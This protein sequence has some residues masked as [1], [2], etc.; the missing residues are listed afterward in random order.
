MSFKQPSEFSSFWARTKYGVWS[1]IALSWLFEVVAESVA[2]LADRYLSTTEL[3]H[4]SI[5][6]F[7]FVIWLFWGPK[8]G[9]SRSNVSVLQ[10]YQFNSNSH[11]DEGHLRT[12]QV[13]MIELQEQH[14]ISQEYTLPF[15]Y[16]CQIYHLLNL[17]HLERIHDFSLNNLKVVE[18]S[19]FQFTT[20][21]GKLRFKTILDS[22]VNP[23]RIWRQPIVEV[24][25]TLHTPY[26]VELSIPVYN[27][28]QITVIF[29]A[30]P[31]NDTEHKLF[32]D[33][34]TDLEWP[35]LPLQILLHFASC[36]TLFEDLPYLRK[37]ADRDIRHLINLN[38]VSDHET[39]WLFRRF[40]DLYGSSVGSFRLAWR[41]L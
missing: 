38:K 7:F 5:T 11:Q 17:K 19:S 41:S 39:M 35:Q 3:L 26:T 31:L 23:L 33:I 4:L 28:K 10:S 16:L 29:N 27:H 21:G 24:G 25:L 37:L 6:S 8:K 2:S 9:F 22:P 30:L 32:I 34:Y 14:T 40:V 36:L 15:P 1:F 20:T 13:R 12:A 18:V